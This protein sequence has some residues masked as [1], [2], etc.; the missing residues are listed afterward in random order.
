MKMWLWQGNFV[1]DN[2]VHKEAVH[3]GL[4]LLLG[5]QQGCVCR[6]GSRGAVSWPGRRQH[7]SCGY[8]RRL[9]GES[10]PEDE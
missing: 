7:G 4:V 10:W 3:T 5:E 8:L 2:E 6:R 1:Q 9:G